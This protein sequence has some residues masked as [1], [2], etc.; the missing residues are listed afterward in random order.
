MNGACCARTPNFLPGTRA[1]PAL[2]PLLHP[3]L[4]NLLHFPSRSLSPTHTRTHRDLVHSPALRSSW[5][6]ESTIRSFGSSRPVGC[7]GETVSASWKQRTGCCRTPAQKCRPCSGRAQHRRR[8]PVCNACRSH[9][10]EACRTT[11]AACARTQKA[12]RQL[13]DPPMQAAGF[14]KTRRSISGGCLRVG[15]HTLATSSSTQ[16]VGSVSGAESECYKLVRCGS[17]AIGLANTKR[18][19]GHEARL[20]I[21]SG[22]CCSTGGLVLGSGSGIKHMGIKCFWLQCKEKNQ[23][24]KIEKIRGLD[25]KRLTTL[26]DLLNI[27]HISG[28]PNSAPKLTSDTEHITCAQRAAMTLVTQAAASDTAVSSSGSMEWTVGRALDG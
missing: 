8:Q 19:L 9:T 23:E 11:P 21:W 26:C 3:I 4:P 22:R 20:R 24:L 7:L 5:A 17:E 2:L 13:M 15:Q 27:K 10:S 25:G 16:K 1:R 12:P 6:A 14:T 18:L 28:R